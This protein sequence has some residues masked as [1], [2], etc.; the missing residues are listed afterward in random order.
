MASGSR[1]RRARRAAPSRPVVVMPTCKPELE[2]EWIDTTDPEHIS[3]DCD[4]DTA[5]VP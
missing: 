1:A 4:D 5:G 2:L 3:D